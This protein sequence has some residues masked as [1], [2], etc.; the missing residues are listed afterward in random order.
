M[1]YSTTSPASASKYHALIFNPCGMARVQRLCKLACFSK[2]V[3]VGPACIG[4]HNAYGISS[5]AK[6]NSLGT[7]L[8]RKRQ[9]LP[10]VIEDSP[11]VS[12]HPPAQGNHFLRCAWPS[13]MQ[14]LMIRGVKCHIGRPQDIFEQPEG[15]MPIACEA[16][17][18]GVYSKAPVYLISP[19]GRIS[20]TRA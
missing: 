7:A 19:P 4:V 6:R 18:K 10:K 8:W 12:V 17:L 14:Q 15:Q 3:P 2:V 16:A 9:L 11:C 13:R 5:H 20:R 1:P